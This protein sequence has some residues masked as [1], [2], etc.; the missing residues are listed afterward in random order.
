VH[1]LDFDEVTGELAHAPYSVPAGATRTVRIRLPRARVRRL[2]GSREARRVEIVATD[3][4]G[5]TAP[6]RQPA[7]LRRGR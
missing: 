6:S 2:L 3:A 1:K 4:S 5:A 7:T